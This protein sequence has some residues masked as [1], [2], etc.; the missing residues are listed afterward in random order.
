MRFWKIKPSMWLPPNQI[1]PYPGN[2]YDHCLTRVVGRRYIFGDIEWM[3]DAALRELVVYAEFCG[4]R[5]LLEVSKQPEQHHP[6]RE[7]QAVGCRMGPDLEPKNA[8]AGSA[9]SSALWYVGRRH[10]PNA[11]LVKSS[12]S[13]GNPH[14]GPAR[15]PHFPN[16]FSQ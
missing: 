15:V 10:F 11:S 1:H 13:R 14:L 16:N 4:V 3:V 6:R 12:K 9:H 8:G 2:V 7:T 5:V